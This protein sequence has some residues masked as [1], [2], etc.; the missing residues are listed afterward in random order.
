MALPTDLAAA[1]VAEH[2]HFVHFYDDPS[3]LIPEIATFIDG[4]LRAGGT[5]IVIASA[6]HLAELAPR[7]SGLG[8][9]QGGDWYPGQLVLLDAERTLEQ[10]MVEGWPDARRFETVL[11]SMVEQA[12][13]RG[14]P[15]HAFGEMVSLL[16]AD[17]RHEAAVVLEGLWND[18][19]GRL[20]F[21]LFCGYP[22]SAF[23]ATCH[24]TAF[25]QVC[26]A[27]QHVSTSGHGFGR[28]SR[29]SERSAT[30]EQRNRALEAEVE[31]LR[32]SERTLL[33]REKELTDFIEN[34]A[35]G[36]HRVGAD[37]TILWANRAELQMLGYRWDEYVGRHIAEFHADQPVIEDILARLQSGETLYDTPA[38]LRC[39]DG[40]VKHVLVHSNA[41]FEDGKL[42]Y[43]R[44]FTR[45]ATVRHE[46]DQLLADAQAASNAKDEFLA[47]LGHELRNPLSPIVTALQ[48]LR[49]RG[50]GRQEREHEIIQ[51]QVDHLVRLVDDLLDVS[52]VTRGKIDLKIE[53]V[54]LGQPVNKA[55]EMA[56][57]LLDQRRHRFVAEVAPGLS[58]QGDPVRLAQV[59]SNLL[60]NAARYTPVG[61]NVALR[62]WREDDGCLAISVKDD[63]VGLPPGMLARVFD[64]FVQGPRG[65]DRAEGGL[66]I[67]LAL[68]KSIVELH[69]GTVEARSEGEGQGCEFIVR[70]PAVARAQDDGATKALPLQPDGKPA[71]ARLRYMVVDDNVDAA[72]TLGELLEALGQEVKVFHEP[73]AALDAAP[74]YRPEVALLDIGLPVLDGYQ[75]AARLREQQGQGGC[76]MFALTGYGQDSDR[77]RCAAAGF[78]QHLV[79]PISV[80]QLVGLSAGP[81]P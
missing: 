37:G 41:Y 61:G 7:L 28:A 14:G 18:L 67:G 17:G 4:A 12:C 73:M 71:V 10:F 6:Q 78:E 50:G 11:G 24:S 56:R 40:S 36:L 16:C 74:L 5:G 9:A 30:L 32:E 53:H 8:P 58:W 19:A 26:A 48:L 46:R 27:H 43:T 23:S 76:R 1:P 29:T 21:S 54:E 13:L 66:G 22:W 62:A 63:G 47:M 45:D 81:R 77:E 39:K 64:L 33:R 49:M 51:R 72:N 52:R 3:Q 44:C 69:G 60:T 42:R 2:R 55:V 59:I 70:L 35:E 38:R 20:R 57:P 80:E 25:Q 15:V 65:L 75:L 34:A 68:V 31:R 79:K